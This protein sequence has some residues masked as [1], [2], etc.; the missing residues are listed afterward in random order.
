MLLGRNYSFPP[1]KRLQLKIII[2]I[3][4]ISVYLTYHQL[5]FFI[6]R[7][8]RS[9]NSLIEALKI[10][11][12]FWQILASSVQNIFDFYAA[13]MLSFLKITMILLYSLLI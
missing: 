6:Y 10:P 5:I 12:I 4:A 7:F 11:E 13:A 8:F 9:G 3:I 1:K 2:I